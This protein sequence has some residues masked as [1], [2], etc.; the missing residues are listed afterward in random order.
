MR[1]ADTL[2]FGPIEVEDEKVIHFPEGIP[3]FEQE[4]EFVIIP[5][6][7]ESPYVF[8]QSLKTP[9]LAFLMTMPFIFFP[10]YEFELDDENQQKLGLERQEDML[11]Y[12]LLTIPQG[13]VQDMTANLV[14]PL[15]INVANQQGRQLVLEHSPYQTKHRL[16]PTDKAKED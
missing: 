7:E 11:L 5:Y 12:V 15:V 14:A 16:F 13:R 8:L 6:D 3:A 2:R 9:D 10:D 1:K 4:H